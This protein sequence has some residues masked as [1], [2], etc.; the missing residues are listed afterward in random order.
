MSLI[1]SSELIQAY[2][3]PRINTSAWERQNMRY[4]RVPGFIKEKNP[5]LPNIIYMHREFID[6]VDVWLTALTFGDLIKEIKT[7]DGCWNVRNKRGQSTLSIHAFG[8]AI[9]FNATHNP[10][11]TTREQAIERGLK[12]FSKEFIKVSRSYM[13]CG[14]DWRT[15]P[16]GMHFQIKRIDA[17]QS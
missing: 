17:I 10:F 12:P 16:D 2:G 15:T 5:F 9:D 14:A 1:S 8:M 13:D 11:K 4:Y 3:D 7:Y 6:V